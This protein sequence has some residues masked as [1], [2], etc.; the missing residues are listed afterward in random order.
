MNDF[1]HLLDLASVRLGG[2]VVAA[3]DEFF[4]SK[5]N[6]VKPESPI[7]IPDKYTDHGKW[8]DGWE[9]RRRRTAGHDWCIVKLGLCG[10]VHSVVVDTTFFT[11]NFPS[12]ASIDAAGLGPDDDPL[13]DSIV[14][15]P[16]AA[17][18]EL[19]GD[20]VN[21][22]AVEDRRRWTHIRL[23]IF[24]DGGVARLRV[25]GEVM[26]DW[27]RILASG[28][29]I[30]LALAVNGGY[31]VDT[32][33]RFYG[34]PRNLLMPYPPMTMADAWETK[35][36][37]SPGH[38]W[39]V[40]RL[41][42]EGAVHAIEIDTAH[43]KGNYP[44]SAS[45]DAATVEEKA[46]GVSSDVSTRAIADWKPLL[47]Q[48][49][50]QPDHLHVFDAGAVGRLS[51]THVRLNMFPDG[52]ISRFRILGAPLVEPRRRAVLRLL[53]AMDA[54]DLRASLAA[55][56]GAQAWIDRVVQQRPFASTDA[57]LR[58]ADSA[59]ETLA[60]ADWR[61]AFR[62]HPRIGESR[63]ERAQSPAASDSS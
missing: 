27:T 35:R 52:G 1:T 61:E 13:A 16:I 47:A 56:N 48:T 55:F 25:M 23:N 39:S 19:A 53:N 7:F 15:H 54:P 42:I 36:R 18:T 22:F 63:A 5:D 51:A 14:W 33:D 40:L 9:T 46:G 44:D 24:P 30:D 11:G 17:R 29:D 60:D 45:V 37:R 58:A 41:G 12:H 8:M 57:L 34:E 21:T 28:A 49:P 38:D 20:S 50:L 2:Q 10:I 32:S 3:N 59:S 43:F 6:L 31:V 4:A 62:H 26:P